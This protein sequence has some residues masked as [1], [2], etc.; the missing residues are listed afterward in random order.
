MQQ[1]MQMA[2]K[3]LLVHPIGIEINRDADDFLNRVNSALS[4]IGYKKDMPVRERD[5][6]LKHIGFKPHEQSQVH[7]HLEE[8]ETS[9]G[10]KVSYG[11]VL[12]RVNGQL[13]PF[14]GKIYG[15]ASK[16]RMKERFIELFG[17]FPMD[18]LEMNIHG[19]IEL[20]F[21]TEAEQKEETI[22][23]RR[24]NHSLRIPQSLNFLN[25]ATENSHVLAH[26]VGDGMFVLVMRNWNSKFTYI[27]IRRLHDIL[28]GQYTMK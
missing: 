10:F 14:Y 6:M 25:H 24:K 5:R 11:G 28:K 18:T 3:E 19:P 7:L 1:L 16:E 15:Y 17:Y 12:S 21:L 20:K 22:S 27:A 23:L 26:S 8:R 9:E 13:E 2:H 4:A